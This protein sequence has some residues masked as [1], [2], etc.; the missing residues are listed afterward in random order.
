MRLPF[1]SRAEHE[2]VQRLF[3]HENKSYCAMQARAIEAGAS[4]LQ[5]ERHATRIA[6]NATAEAERADRRYADLLARFVGP[7]ARMQLPAAERETPDEAQSEIAKVI[8][9]QS[10]GDILLANHLRRH[11]RQ[12]KKEGKTPDE[13]VGALVEWTSTEHM[14]VEQ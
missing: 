3:A 9:E 10:E 7:G 13:I 6:E 1:V 4:A 2:R 14:A 5:W 8:R 12:L 11:A